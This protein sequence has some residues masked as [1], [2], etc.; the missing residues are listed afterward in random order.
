[1]G[2]K[3]GCLVVLV[4]PMMLVLIVLLGLIARPDLKHYVPGWKY[5]E[6]YQHFAHT[7]LSASAPSVEIARGDSLHTVLLKLRKA[8][9]QSGS[10]LEWQLLAYQVG[11]AGNLKFGDYALVPA[12]SPHDLLQ[13]MRHGKGEHYRFTIVEGWNI[14]QL[15]AAL[16]QATPLVHRAGMLEDATL[17][18]QLGFPGEHPEGRFLPETYLYQRGDS[19]LDVL[20]RAHAAMQKALA[21]T[22]AARDPALKLHT[23]DEALILASIVEKESALSTER[24]K[25][26]GVFLHRIARGMRLQ[27][28][29]TV[30]YGLGSIYD[31]NIRK[32]DL[33]TPTPYNTYVHTGLTP[34]PISMPGQ[35]A[36]RAVTRPALGDALYFVALGDGSGGHTFSSSLQQHNAAV[37]RYL[38]RLRER[39]SKT[40]E[41][42]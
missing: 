10:D 28:D 25:I 31:G 20:R 21:E 30:I 26:A 35:D 9:V 29:S 11:A 3:R 19:D 39:E 38:Q 13:R 2:R 42:Q 8:G 5:Y 37:A 4:A 34:T 23:P 32:R 27:A 15:R 40:K 6:H 14:R 18:A 1:M 7:P 17:M 22:W 12:V 24:P 33:K 36:L 16:R 41:R